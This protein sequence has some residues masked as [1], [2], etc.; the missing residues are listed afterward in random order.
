MAFGSAARSAE[1]LKLVEA[2]LKSGHYFDE[3]V[4]LDADIV[5]HCVSAATTF[6][7]PLPP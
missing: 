6:C 2:D 5:C 3:V 7:T 4:P 1:E